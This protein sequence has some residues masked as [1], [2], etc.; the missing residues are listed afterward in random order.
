MWYTAIHSINMRE[1]VLGIVYVCNGD[2]YTVA[3][4]S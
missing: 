2:H 3:N 4:K 1:K